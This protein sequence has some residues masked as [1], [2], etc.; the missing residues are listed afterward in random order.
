MKA[1]IIQTVKHTSRNSGR[2]TTLKMYCSREQIPDFF[3]MLGYDREVVE[4]KVVLY[5]PSNCKNYKSV[6]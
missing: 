4:S 2:E 6:L 5:R 3:E 1:Y